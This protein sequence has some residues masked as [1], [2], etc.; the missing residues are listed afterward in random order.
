MGVVDQF[1][2]DRGLSDHCP[3]WLEIDKNNWGPK[4]FKFN[5]ECFSF[6][7]FY[8]FVEKEWNEFRVEGRGDFVLKEKIH[9]L[10]GRLKWWNKEVFDRIDLEVEEGVRDINTLFQ[11]LTNDIIHLWYSCYRG[12]T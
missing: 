10:K 6:D 11:K 2:G 4:P 5:N 3:I 8:L 1:V 9:L 12:L 7:S